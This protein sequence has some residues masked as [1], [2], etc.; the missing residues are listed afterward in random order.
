MLGK[1]FRLERDCTKCSTTGE[2]SIPF[3]KGKN[4]KKHRI[5]IVGE[6]PGIVE[7]NKDPDKGET[8]N[9]YNEFLKN[10]RNFYSLEE[11]SDFFKKERLEKNRMIN[12]WIILNKWACGDEWGWPEKIGLKPEDIAFSDCYKCY[13]V[14]NKMRKDCKRD[15]LEKEV[16][17]LNPKTI[18][19][20]GSVAREAIEEIIEKKRIISNDEVNIFNLLHTSQFNPMKKWSWIENINENMGKR[21]PKIK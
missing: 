3:Y 11:Y 16:K 15:F 5:L 14:K 17:Y 19:T 6:K 13:E 10:I 20:L 1:L 8:V 4:Y 2:R 9:Q 21:I 18:V 12:R 7:K